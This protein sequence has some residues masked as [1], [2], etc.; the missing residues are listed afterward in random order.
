MNVTK[1]MCDDCS[2]HVLAY[3]CPPH[4]AMCNGEMRSWAQ[5]LTEKRKADYADRLWEKDN[6]K[7]T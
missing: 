4:C 1:W 6:G 2:C 5:R 7:Q 3:E